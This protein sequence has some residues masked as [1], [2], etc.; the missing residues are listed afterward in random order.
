M[1]GSGPIAAGSNDAAHSVIIAISAQ[2]Q[3]SVGANDGQPP[4]INDEFT[5]IE[6]LECAL[7]DSLQL[8]GPGCNEISLQDSW[9]LVSPSVIEI[10]NIS[11]VPG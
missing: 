3:V 8:V 10:F 11:L 4:N 9:C 2:L 5:V 1:D 7:A 6:T